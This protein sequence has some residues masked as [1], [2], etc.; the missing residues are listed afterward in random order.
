[1]IEERSDLMTGDLRYM[2]DEEFSLGRAEEMAL[3]E[4]SKDKD[5]N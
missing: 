1:M 4:F 2:L 3:K 5:R